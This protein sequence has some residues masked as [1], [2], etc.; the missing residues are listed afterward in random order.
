MP[1]TSDFANDGTYLLSPGHFATT[2]A[3][4]SSGNYVPGYAVATGA[5]RTQSGS[6]PDDIR[7]TVDAA[8]RT[9]GCHSCGNTDPGTSNG[10]F[11]PDHQPPANQVRHAESRGMSVGEVRLYPHCLNCSRSQFRQAGRGSREHRAG[12]GVMGGM[13]NDTDGVAS[14]ESLAGFEMGPFGPMS[15]DW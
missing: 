12:L 7:D 11:I 10:H 9:H 1:A 4:D 3:N 13:M 8:G 2:G 15:D 6:F 5:Q 14:M